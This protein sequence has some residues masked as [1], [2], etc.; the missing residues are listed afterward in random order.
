MPSVTFL[1]FHSSTTDQPTTDEFNQNQIWFGAVIMFSV[2]FIALLCVF[3]FQKLR[4]DQKEERIGWT[5]ASDFTDLIVSNE[6]FKSIEA[7]QQY[8]SNAKITKKML[9]ANIIMLFF[10]CLNFY[11]IFKTFWHYRMNDFGGTFDSMLFGD[12][13]TKFVAMIELG[14]IYAAILVSLFCYL[15]K[16]YK[17]AV[18]VTVSYIPNMSA[19]TLFCFADTR[20]ITSVM[21]D[22]DGLKPCKSVANCIENASLVFMRVLACAFFFTTAIW[23]FVIKV[24]QINYIYG[25]D[26]DTLHWGDLIVVVGV[27][28]QFANMYSVFVGAHWEYMHRWIDPKKMSKIDKENPEWKKKYDLDTIICKEVCETNGLTGFFWLCYVFGDVGNVARLFV[29]PQEEEFDDRHK[30]SMQYIAMKDSNKAVQ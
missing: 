30:I 8:T 23:I 12:W 29:A 19:M 10:I 18:W 1:L 27:A 17:G 7:L 9:G 2:T 21:F 26:L 5:T 13:G 20:L 25:A 15:F 24:K 4:R 14:F 3:I 16:H 22:T 28:R 6:S 11:T